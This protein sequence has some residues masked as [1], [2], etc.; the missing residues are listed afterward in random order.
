MSH[1]AIIADATCDLSEELRTSLDVTIVPG[2]LCLPNGEE[3]PAMP[4]WKYHS[5]EEFYKLLKKDPTSFTTSP[6]NV[7]EFE[8]AFEEQAANGV[9]VLAMCISSG[10]SGAHNFMQMARKNVLD[11]YPNAKILCIDTLRYG[12][13]FGLM[14]MWACALRAAGKSVEETAR[15]MEEN[16]TCFRQAGWLD[17]LKFVASK[18]RINHAQAFFG[19]LAGIK[20]IGELDKNGL[21][22]VLVKVKGAKAAY[23]VMLEYMEKTI[24]DPQEQ[25][26]LIAQSDRY[27][28]AL[29]YKALIE[30]RFSPKEV[31]I[32][33]VHPLCGANIGPGLMA[34]YYFG[35]PT[36]ENLEEEKKLMEA[37]ANK[38]N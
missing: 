7:A 14:V 32:T 19:T 33:D 18:G 21:T 11:R 24:R 38:G 10:I 4:E 26:I 22:T 12:P 8:R 29:E 37:I 31:I 35:S 28:Q 9:D 36:S 2:H 30:E 6:A 1:F 25:T 3:V 27:K 17:D 34:A 20:P 15:F 5:R 13:G 16:K 23:N